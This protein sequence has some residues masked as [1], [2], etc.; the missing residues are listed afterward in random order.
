MSQFNERWNTLACPG[1]EKKTHFT[2]GMNSSVRNKLFRTPRHP[3]H[4]DS[5]G[6]MLCYII[7]KVGFCS[8]ETEGVTFHKKVFALRASL[9]AMRP[10]KFLQ[11]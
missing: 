3:G 6:Q 7:L 2:Q 9:E 5:V 1:T 10:I 11:C 4:C 8:T